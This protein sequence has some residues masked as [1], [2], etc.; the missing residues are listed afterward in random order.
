MKEL[1]SFKSVSDMLDQASNY[2]HGTGLFFERIRRGT[3]SQDKVGDTP[4]CMH[5]YK[6]LPG[7]YRIPGVAVDSVRH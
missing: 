1:N 4:L 5:Q 3:L 6:S 2:L 7:T